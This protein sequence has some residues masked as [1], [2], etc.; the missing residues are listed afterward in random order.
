MLSIARGFTFSITFMAL[1]LVSAIQAVGQTNPFSE[2]PLVKP[3]IHV[4]SPSLFRPWLGGE[5]PLG[6]YN[7]TAFKRLRLGTISLTANMQAHIDAIENTVHVPSYLEL[8]NARTGAVMGILSIYSTQDA[9]VYF[10]GNAIM[11]LNERHPLLCGPRYTRKFVITAKSLNEVLQPIL[12]L[13]SETE[14]LEPT[15]L[16]ESPS[17]KTVVATVLPTTKVIVVGAPFESSPGE[18]LHLLVKTPFGLTG[19]HRRDGTPGN[20]SLDIYQCN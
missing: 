4:E 5:V 14:V 20:G 9:D 12:Y 8:I 13:G 6:S 17:S 15:P 2:R 3:H 16:Y 7:P 11:Y 1:G 19:W 18:K 10:N